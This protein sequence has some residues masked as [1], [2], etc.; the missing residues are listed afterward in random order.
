MAAILTRVLILRLLL[1]YAAQSV[2]RSQRASKQ[3]EAAA[4]RERRNEVRCQARAGSLSV[5]R[6]Q[7][8]C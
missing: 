6:N 2:S 7:K 8:R 5:Q 4:E 3:V 1:L